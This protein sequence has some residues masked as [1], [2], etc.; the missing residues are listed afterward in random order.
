M[1]R[2][3]YHSFPLHDLAPLVKNTIP[4]IF[5]DTARPGPLNRFSYIFTDPRRVCTAPSMRAVPLLLQQLDGYAGKSWIAGYLTYEASYGLEQRLLKV[6][7]RRTGFPENYG[8][9]GVFYT[10]YI[11]D[12]RHGQWNQPLPVQTRCQGPL[13]QV[14][15]ITVKNTIS[16]PLYTNKLRSIRRFI[17]RGHTYQINF[18]YDVLL[19]TDCAAFDLYCQLRE[20]QKAAYCSFISLNGLC[21][22]SF[23]P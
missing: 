9:F 13:K 10:P 3:Q 1:P 20:N 21:I 12:H 4:F 5:L 11:F 14:P 15:A 16:E 19:Q 22:A 2:P 18:T 6:C 23:S 8:W 17:A 7:G